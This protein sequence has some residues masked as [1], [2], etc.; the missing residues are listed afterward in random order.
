MALP[1]LGINANLNGALP[2]SPDSE[3]NMR[4]DDAPTV[5]DSA[6]I[7]ASVGPDSGLHPEF[8]SGTWNGSKIGIPYVIVDEG[9]PPVP[10][11]LNL[12]TEEGDPGHYPIPKDAPIEE[13]VDRHMIVVQRDP[14]APNGLGKLYETYLTQYDESGWSGYGAIFDMTKGD[15]QRPDG[16]TSADAAGLPIFPGLLKYDEVQQAVARDGEKGVVPHALRFTLEDAYTDN[17]YVGAASHYAG[18][19]G[20]AAPFG[21]RVRLKADFEYAP[22]WPVEVKVILNTLKTYG[23]ILADNGGN[24]FVGGAP[25]ERWDNDDLHLLKNVRGEDFEVVD[26][27]DLTPSKHPAAPIPDAPPAEI[28]SPAVPDMSAEDETADRDDGAS[29]DGGGKDGVLHGGKGNDTRGDDSGGLQREGGPRS[30]KLYGSDG[31]DTLLGGGGNDRLTGGAGNDRLDGG[32]GADEL[33][34]GSGDDTLM[35]GA[36]GDRLY[37][38]NGADRLTSGDGPDR[39][40]F[41]SIGESGTTASTRDVITDF[42]VGSDLIHLAKINAVQGGGGNAA[43]SFIGKDDFT[44]AGQLRFVQDAANNRTLVEGNVNGDLA[45]DFQIELTGVHSLS[46]SDFV[47]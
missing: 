15:H 39:F 8:G 29:P 36:A 22:S 38:G 24:W 35:G 10:F 42:E 3:W 11:D 23:M 37:G 6:R 47:L 5:G 16:W 1:N 20:G 25:D 12:Y 45:A 32:N 27:S 43:F 31:D 34:G 9:Q 7:I 41:T 46:A 30:D 26:T 18:T 2:F 14:S 21:M 17:S 13:G 33:R 4:V 40:F 44:A 19:D 28:D